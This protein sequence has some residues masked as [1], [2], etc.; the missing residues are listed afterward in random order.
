VTYKDAVGSTTGLASYW[1]LGETSGTSST[2]AKGTVTG[3]YS[4]MS[5]N[6]PSLL[7]NDTDAAVDLNGSSSMARYG[8]VYDFAGTSAFSL[9]AWVKP[10]T[11]DAT[12]RRLFSKEWSNSSGIQGY[13][14]VQSSSKL[15]FARLRNGAY[16]AAT[17]PSLAVG[18]TYHVVATYDGSA[19]R[20]YV[21][22]ALVSTGAS[23][24]QSVVEGTSVF[25]IGAKA[26]GGGNFA[27][28]IDEAAVYTGA[29]S[30]QQV[31]D[32]YKVGMGA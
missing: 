18:R 26:S 11:V 9:E 23:T 32:H 15:Q 20:L 16:Q 19:M 2:A 3:T 6:R 1:R 17:A 24:T 29:L 22:G 12:S 27:G 28:T 14:L 13:D 7:A 21:N 8:D 31:T 30:D 10:T 25:T 4:G 5:L